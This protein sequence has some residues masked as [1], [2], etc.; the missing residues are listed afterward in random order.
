MEIKK[1][2][3]ILQAF[4]KHKVEPKSLMFG[5]AV[6]SEG[7]TVYYD[8][9][10]PEVGAA[11]FITDP[12]GNYVAAP[13]GEHT[14]EDGTVLVVVQEDMNGVMVGKIA[15]V[16]PATSAPDPSSVVP[17]EEPLAADGGSDKEAKAIIR[18]IIEETRFSAEISEELTLEEQV[19][20]FKN[21]INGMRDQIAEFEEKAQ[22]A[23]ANAS[24]FKAQNE[25][26]A[27]LVEEMS[28]EPAAEP[29]HHPKKS[30]FLVTESK[31]DHMGY[32]E[33]MA[34]ARKVNN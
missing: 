16:R 4:S 32:V 17:A 24:K 21:S 28:K 13:E 30:K 10:T 22:K 18:S 33:R 2:L 14:L 5:E 7:V 9:D 15:E 26:L 20:Q 19:E 29:A 3:A 11:I 6:T 1:K 12:E 31:K 23:E 8:G 25:D 34:L 27:K